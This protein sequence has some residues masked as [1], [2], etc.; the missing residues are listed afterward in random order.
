MVAVMMVYM[1]VVGKTVEDGVDD[2]VG[3]TVEDG[4]SDDV[5][6]DSGGEDCRGWWH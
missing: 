5:V 6:Y 2:V 3:K 1:I 4:G